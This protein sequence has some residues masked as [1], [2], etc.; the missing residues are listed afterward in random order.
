MFCPGIAALPHASDVQKNTPNGQQEE[1][2]DTRPSA[3]K[4]LRENEQELIRNEPRTLAAAVRKVLCCYGREGDGAR[5]WSSERGK[6][7]AKQVKQAAR[8][9]GGMSES[10]SE[11]AADHV[12][13]STPTPEPQLLPQP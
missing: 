10:L 11:T 8:Q 2:A 3:L 1:D 13:L 5:S 12:T 6:Q 7:E 9:R 4:R